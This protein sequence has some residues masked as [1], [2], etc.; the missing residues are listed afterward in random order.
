MTKDCCWIGPEKMLAC[1]VIREVIVIA[2]F[3]CP[4]ERPVFNKLSN[5]CEDWK[6][7][8]KPASTL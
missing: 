3:T 8:C 4:F 1:S 6:L 7:F 2:L 5:P